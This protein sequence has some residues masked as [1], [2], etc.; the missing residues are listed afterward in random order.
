VQEGILTDTQRQMNFRQMV[1]IY[2]LTGGPQGS[3]I[4]PQML[5]EAAPLQGKSEI[6]E[7][8]QANQEQA[9]KQAQQQAQVQE[10]LLKT[11]S[12]SMQAKAISDVALSKERFTRS[13][14]NMGLEDERASKAIQDRSDAAL[15]R[16]KAMKEL[17]SMDDER[18]LKY[19]NI[20]RMM[21]E[22]NRVKEEQIKE[23]DVNISMRANEAQQ[24]Q[25]PDMNALQQQMQGQ[26]Q[27][28]SPQME[29]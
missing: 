25:A 27:A 18:L 19:M 14:A 13:V 10:Q 3:P 12:E 7:K 4:T 6:N 23:D 5:Y 22:G 26:Q 15:Q 16:V 8:I 17:Q 9:Q 2:Q 1:D 28:Q 20:V 24:N 21:E 29:M 11:Q